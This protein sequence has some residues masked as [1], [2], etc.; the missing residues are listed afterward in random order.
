MFVLNNHRLIN[1]ELQ[2]TYLFNAILKMKT[3]FLQC[4]NL[5]MD[6]NNHKKL[7]ESK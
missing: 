3:N 4:L 1:F 6:V 2:I 7:V 5:F